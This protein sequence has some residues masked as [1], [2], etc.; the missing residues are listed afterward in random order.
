LLQNWPSN[1]SNVE[2]DEYETLVFVYSRKLDSLV[3]AN[4]ITKSPKEEEESPPHIKDAV[5]DLEEETKNTLPPFQG[6]AIT[7]SKDMTSMPTP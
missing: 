5:M 2:D 1:A 6:Y 3:S 7:Y 4:Y